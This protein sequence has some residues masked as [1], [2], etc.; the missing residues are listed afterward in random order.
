VR[1]SRLRKQEAVLLCRQRLLLQLLQLLRLHPAC[2]SWLQLFNLL[3]LLLQLQGLQHKRRQLLLVLD[4]ARSFRT[5]AARISIVVNCCSCCTMRACTCLL[6]L[7][8]L[9]RVLLP[10][11]T[12]AAGARCSTGSCSHSRVASWLLGHCT[13]SVENLPNAAVTPPLQVSLHG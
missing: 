4:G 6:L 2:T 7:L 13:N 11:D 10:S 12:P 8:L 1:A 5:A 3:L 9:L